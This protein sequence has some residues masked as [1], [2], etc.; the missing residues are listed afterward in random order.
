MRLISIKPRIFISYARE[1]EA[2]A[3]FIYKRL[4]DDRY[5]PFMDTEKILAGDLFAKK[6]LSELKQCDGVV[7]VISS[8]SV[9]SE[10]CEFEVYYAHI[11]NK[12]IIPVRFKNAAYNADSPLN[13]LQKETNYITL[14]ETSAIATS[15]VY[16]QIK[17][18]LRFARKRARSRLLKTT[19]VV[20][21]AM[22]VLALFFTYGIKRINAYNYNQDK[23]RLLNDVKNA[24]NLL[25]KNEIT[26][27]AAKFKGDDDLVSGLHFIAANAQF[28]D[29]ARLNAKMLSSALLL[30]FSLA[31]RQ[32]INAIDWQASS[33]DNNLVT[34]S[35]FTGGYMAHDTFSRVL[36]SNVYFKGFEGSSEGVSLA[37][38]LF[39]E[40]SFHSITFDQTKLTDVKFDNC[41]FTGSVLNTTNFGGVG[42]SSDSSAG[43]LI[44]DGRLTSFTNCVFQN[45]NP[46]D[47]PHTVVLGKEEEMQFN[48][49][50]F[51]G[52]RFIGLVRPEWFRNC[53]FTDCFF[54]K[55]FTP[56]L[57]LQNNKLTNPQ[58][59]AEECEK[60]VSN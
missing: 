24:K 6:I 5:E 13:F 60:L 58:H 49:V 41:S 1:E 28:P 3:G 25:R 59:T 33:L 55:G 51:E 46:P 43:M 29:A 42:F 18:R 56:S 26:A 23:A 38:L 50:V 34:N 19:V 16:D 36:F 44:T 47:P 21:G 20:T 52:C 22:L 2:L 7:T 37:G 11:L 31:K 12:V 4:S 39:S 8:D 54:P 48:G 30:S 57:L 27:Y 17:K 32:Y 10:W 40:C 14:N 45:C 15:L 9:R 53:F 35:S